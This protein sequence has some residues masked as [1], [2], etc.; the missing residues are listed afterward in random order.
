V[1]GPDGLGPA[2]YPR[3]YDV[4]SGI[5]SANAVKAEGTAL[6]AVGIENGAPGP[7][8]NLRAISG[9]TANLDYYAVNPSQL[10]G[11]LRQFAL[12]QCAGTVNVTKLVIPAAR[13]GDL[14]AAL[15]APGWAFTAAPA[16][17]T[18]HQGSTGAAGAV[19]FA[20]GTTAQPVTLTETGQ[21]GYTLSPVNGANAVC[22][23]SG[24]ATVP[25]TNAGPDG[26]TVDA[27]G[28][29][30]VRCD[31]YNQ[32]GTGPPDPAAVRVDKAWVING[33][34]YP[35]GDQ[36]PDFQAALALSPVYPTGTQPAFGTDFYGYQAGET[37]TI[38]ETG[39]LPAGCA[40]S[41]SGGLGTRVLAAGLNSYL[42]TNTVTCGVRSAEL[43]LVKAISNPFT[44]VKTAPLTSWLLTARQA[45][46]GKTA[47]RGRTGVTGG[48]AAGTAYLLTES[49]VTGYRQYAD[50]ATTLAKGATGSWSCVQARPA[51]TGHEVFG[52][53]DG[54]VTVPFGVHAVC[55]ATNV[56]T[57][58]I[59]VGPPATGGG[60]APARPAP[61]LSVAGLALLGAGAVAS[62]AAL[63]RRRRP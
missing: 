18:P 60:P 2:S 21:P 52:G 43:T 31:V 39:S 11:L 44:N 3:F 62:A 49:A 42:V 29:D 45:S 51:G 27:A 48:V 15:P 22:T 40:V 30:I 32:V 58:A 54:T 9:P 25:V 5:F 37:V 41:E 56:L 14:A 24:G 63:R 23:D 57:R 6:V 10:A 53:G 4:E 28:S 61:A 19:S 7:R 34:T 8:D 13:P 35:D 46:T 1:S 36:D 12:R 33:T 20:A 17:I 26:F 47:L 59:P 38:G 16:G 50:P 55:T